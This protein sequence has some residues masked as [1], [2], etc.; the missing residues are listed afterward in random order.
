VADYF[1]KSLADV[2]MQKVSSNS[3]FLDVSPDSSHIVTGGF[4]QIGHVIDTKLSYN[5]AIPCFFDQDG[6]MKNKPVGRE[7][8][9]TR[10]GKLQT[11]ENL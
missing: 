1:E 11:K 5:L 3:F 6:F 2:C 9:Y 7:S 8:L 4:N 10:S